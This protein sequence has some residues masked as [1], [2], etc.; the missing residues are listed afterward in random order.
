LTI[1]SCLAVGSY[2][3]CTW[4]DTTVF[5]SNRGSKQQSKQPV[6]KYA[7]RD[8]CLELKRIKSSAKAMQT[9]NLQD[10]LRAE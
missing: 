7:I 4:L 3:K 9:N 1:T 10:C 2:K 6:G 5:S 8:S